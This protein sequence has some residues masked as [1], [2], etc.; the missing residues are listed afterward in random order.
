MHINLE[1]DEEDM[2]SSDIPARLIS[3][4]YKFCPNDSFDLCVP[5]H[6]FV[7][8]YPSILSPPY[9]HLLKDVDF[10]SYEKKIAELKGC[11][12]TNVLSVN[13]FQYGP[14]EYRSRHSKPDL[15]V[16]VGEYYHSQ[17]FGVFA[18][19]NG[20]QLV[21]FWD[22]SKTSDVQLC[23]EILS[24]IV[25]KFI[26]PLFDCTNEEITNLENEENV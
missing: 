11:D 9:S 23:E 20:L 14:Y 18:R 21:K 7:N 12:N 13:Y 6:H 24:I 2:Y 3:I 8:H 1:G 17:H 25:D 5:D 22:K 19:E 16:F 26:P 10:Y 4:L 15:T